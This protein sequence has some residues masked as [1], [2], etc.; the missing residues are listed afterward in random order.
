M[1]DS[2]YSPYIFAIPKQHLVFDSQDLGDFHQFSDRS[3]MTH[4]K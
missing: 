4:F 3:K 1:F 2:Q